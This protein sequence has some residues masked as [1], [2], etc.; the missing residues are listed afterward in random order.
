MYDVS[1]LHLGKQRTSLPW[2]QFTLHLFVDRRYVQ[3]WRIDRAGNE[4]RTR[5]KK[6]TRENERKRKEFVLVRSREEDVKINSTGGGKRL[7]PRF[8]AERG[9][10]LMQRRFQ[11]RAQVLSVVGENWQRLTLRDGKSNGINERRCWKRGSRRVRRELD[12]RY[13]CIT[14]TYTRT[15]T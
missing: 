10:S 1:Y 4:H 9:V 8:S 11:R 13:T 14:H 5:K 3:H 15:Y 6:K 2:S 12:L 7:N